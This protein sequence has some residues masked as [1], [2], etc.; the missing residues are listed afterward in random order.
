MVESP[1]TRAEIPEGFTMEENECFTS[2]G[3]L[4]RLTPM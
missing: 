2:T 4:R 3:I 1:D